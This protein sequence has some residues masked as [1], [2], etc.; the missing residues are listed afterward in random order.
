MCARAV[1]LVIPESTQCCRPAPLWCLLRLC[2]QALML[3]LVLILL[4]MLVLLAGA[5][6]GV[7]RAPRLAS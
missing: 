1:R 2:L 3:A 5:D 6:A 4:L 7:G